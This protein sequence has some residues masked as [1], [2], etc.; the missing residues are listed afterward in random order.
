MRTLFLGAGP[1]GSLYAHLLQEKGGE[2]TVLAHG[3]RYDWLK[4]NGLVLL[5]ELTGQKDSSRVNLVN[6]LKPEDEHD[7]VIVLIRKNKLLPV[8]EILASHPRPAAVSSEPALERLPRNQARRLS[9]SSSE[10][11]CL[12]SQ[13]YAA[14]CEASRI[15]RGL[16]AA[17]GGSAMAGASGPGRVENAG[18]ILKK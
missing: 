8:F 7:L 3:E 1:L 2:V 16:R 12:I 11:C 18:S 10:S 13:P 4:E 17:I 9:A 14:R 5:N 6:E 15:T